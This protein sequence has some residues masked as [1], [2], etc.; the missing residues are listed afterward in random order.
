MN[1]YRI[2]VGDIIEWYEIDSLRPEVPDAPCIVGIVQHI[3]SQ[4]FLATIGYTKTIA[5]VTI[6]WSD[7]TSIEGDVVRDLSTEDLITGIPYKL[8][9]GHMFKVQ[10]P[11]RQA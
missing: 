4:S 10:K 9:T 2:D 1:W 7:S 3:Y 5:L 11:I 8:R 6:L